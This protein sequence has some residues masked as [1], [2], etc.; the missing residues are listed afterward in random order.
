[1]KAELGDLG[2][3]VRGHPLDQVANRLEDAH[4][5][6]EGIHHYVQQI[7]EVLVRV[8]DLREPFAKVK[9]FFIQTSSRWTEETYEQLQNS[10]GQK[11]KQDI[12]FSKQERLTNRGHLRRILRLVG[13][14]KRP[15]KKTLCVKTTIKNV[16]LGVSGD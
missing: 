2:D 9:V 12:N 4:V 13:R 10:C 6:F 11:L 3:D 15:E 8:S 5:R 7:V 16:K 1:M 14:E